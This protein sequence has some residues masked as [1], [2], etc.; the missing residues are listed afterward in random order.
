MLLPERGIAVAV[1]A[2]S[3]DNPSGLYKALLDHLLATPGTDWLARSVAKQEKDGADAVKQLSVAESLRP[4]SELSL[5]LKAYEGRY[6]DPWYG[7]IIVAMKRGKLHI[8]FT[9]TPSFKGNLEPW[10][11]DSFRT[12]FPQSAGED[13]VVTFTVQSGAVMKVAMKALSP[14]ADFSYDFQDLTFLPR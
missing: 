13:A 11:R 8:D 3:E 4:P 1:Y 9:R 2:N 6:S 10:G 12:R 5:P 14:L 7:D